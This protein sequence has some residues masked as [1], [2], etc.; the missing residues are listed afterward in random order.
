MLV[1]LLSIFYFGIAV[2]CMLATY[3]EGLSSGKATLKFRMEGMIL[4][5]FWPAL[6]MIVLTQAGSDRH[7]AQRTSAT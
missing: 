1:T 7:M 5:L 6:V 3:L 2:L 4:S